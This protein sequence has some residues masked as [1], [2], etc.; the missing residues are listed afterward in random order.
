MKERH[1]LGGVCPSLNLLVN[2]AKRR[3]SKPDTINQTTKRASM[4]DHAS[5]QSQTG[6]LPSL[7]LSLVGVF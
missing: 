5:D 1:H 6:L 3:K 4:A 7:P 2:T